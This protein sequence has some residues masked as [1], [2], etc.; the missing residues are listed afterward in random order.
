[1]LIEFSVTN[2]RSIKERQTLSMLPSERVKVVERKNSLFNIPQYKNLNLLT[3]SAIYGKN[4]AGKSNI[5]KAFKAIEWLVLNS[6][7]FTQGDKLLANETFIFDTNYVQAPTLFEIDFLANDNKRYLYIIEFNKDEVLKEELHYY[8][9]TETGKTTTRKLYTRHANQ[10]ISYGSDFKGL[11]KPIEERTRT[12]VL[13]LSKSI[14]ENNTFL[15]PIFHFFKSGF[16]ISDFTEGYNDIQTK[17]FVKV[18]SEK[19][20]T[21]MKILNNALRNIDTG[22]LELTSS[23]SDKL[24][25]NIIFENTSENELSDTEKKKRDDLVDALKMEMQAVHRL[26]N[27]TNEIGTRNISLKEE[28]EGTQ[29]FIAVFSDLIQL[30]K[31]GSLMVVDEFD[32]SFHPYLTQTL[33]SLLANPKVNTKGS[34]LIFTTH[35]ITLLDILDDDQINLVQK[36]FIGATEIYAIS[37]IRGLRGDVANS[38]RY[39]R[40]EFE[41]IPNINKSSLYQSLELQYEK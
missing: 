38:K 10:P 26:F 11:R 29:K 33:I 19:N 27:G 16:R 28:S 8:I 20:S 7:R 13:F 22:V 4:S 9:T 30:I 23:K 6:H 40:G 12:N 34:Q 25:K 41:A 18:A 14:N 24:P 5:I 17:F 21:D 3:L 2:F 15:D 1:M 37:D 35:D 36:D 31:S 39:L 32:K